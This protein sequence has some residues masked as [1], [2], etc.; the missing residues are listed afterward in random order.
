[1]NNVKDVTE[2]CKF[3]IRLTS[4]NE[5]PTTPWLIEQVLPSNTFVHHR[6][7][8]IYIETI[9]YTIEDNNKFSIGTEGYLVL[10]PDGK[11]KITDER[12]RQ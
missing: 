3:R 7:K 5:R 10:Y 12:Q 1:M 8:S 11:A 4:E 2:P 6:V 9:A